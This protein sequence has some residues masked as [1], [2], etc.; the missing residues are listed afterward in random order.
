MFVRA[1]VAAM[2]ANQCR[3]DEHARI[4]RRLGCRPLLLLDPSKAALETTG[5]F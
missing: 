1:A 4:G 5:H 2:E 3:H